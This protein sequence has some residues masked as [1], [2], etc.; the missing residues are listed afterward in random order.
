MN[1]ESLAELC[2]LEE[3]RENSLEKAIHTGGRLYKGI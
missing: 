1:G 3:A 2:L